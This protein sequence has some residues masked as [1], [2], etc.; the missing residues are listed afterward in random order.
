MS[1]GEDSRH[2]RRAPRVK[3]E[4][5]AAAGGDD[6]VG[7]GDPYAAIASSKDKGEKRL[8][9][10]VSWRQLTAVGMGC[11]GAAPGWVPEQ[12]GTRE[13]RDDMGSSA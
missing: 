1:E 8:V 13:C 10:S 11:G 12:G 4:M 7:G 9:H 5:F 6:N 2:L 3:K